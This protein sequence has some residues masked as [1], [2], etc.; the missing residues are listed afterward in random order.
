M[1]KFPEEL[2][3]KVCLDTMAQNQYKLISETRNNIV[4]KINK[5]VEDCNT[6]MILELP[7]RLWYKHKV[8]LIKE[9]LE[10]FDKV[11]TRSSSQHTTVTNTVTTIEDIPQNVK[12][13]IIEFPIDVE[14]N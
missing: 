9:L 12:L 11:K 7:D 3:R 14:Q 8:T 5:Y 10:R 6:E 2:N 13:V 1:D 4:Q